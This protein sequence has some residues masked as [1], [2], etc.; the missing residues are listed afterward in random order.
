MK[1][2]NFLLT[3][4]I[5]D[6]FYFRYVKI[7]RSTITWKENLPHVNSVSQFFLFFHF[8]RYWHALVGTCVATTWQWSFHLIS[9][10]T[11]DRTSLWIPSPNLPL[12]HQIN[13]FSAAN[14]TDLQKGKESSI[15]WEVVARCFTK[16][17]SKKFLKIRREI[18]VYLCDSLFL[19]TVKSLQAVMLVILLKRDPRTG[20]SEPAVCRSSVR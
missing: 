2:L 3:I 4:K 20:V 16:N 8:S 1:F 11:Q 19:N 10:T 7:P 17:L 6:F 18:H 12:L 14:L 13:W 5:S 9:I 15:M